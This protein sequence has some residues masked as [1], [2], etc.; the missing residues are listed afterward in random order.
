MF[1]VVLTQISRLISNRQQVDVADT[2]EERGY[3]L[4]PGSN[5]TMV[6]SFLEELGWIRQALEQVDIESLDQ[7][8]KTICQILNRHLNE[9]DREV[10]AYLELGEQEKK[11]F[12]SL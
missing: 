12:D 8:D 6:S 2:L 5:T 10:I 7:V 9:A 1:K 11:Y 3:V 4:Q